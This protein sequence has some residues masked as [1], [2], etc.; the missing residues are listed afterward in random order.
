MPKVDH[1]GVHWAPGAIAFLHQ[2]D[3]A[4]NIIGLGEPSPFSVMSRGA[5]NH[6]ILLET[7]TPREHLPLFRQVLAQSSTARFLLPIPAPQPG[8]VSL[9]P[10][11]TPHES[12][13]LL[14]Q[15]L[16]M[17]S[18]LSP[19]LYAGWNVPRLLTALDR[20][21]V[22]PVVLTE[23]RTTDAANVLR[24]CRRALLAPSKL[25]VQVD[26]DFPPSSAFPMLTLAPHNLI[27]LSLLPWEAFGAT[28]LRAHMRRNWDEKTDWFID[29]GD[30]LDA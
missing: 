24:L 1:Y 30:S 28:V 17:S 3:G 5:C 9:Y 15:L 29:E 23:G 2:D 4:R 22:Q 20:T 6:H 25:L 7:P 8:G 26:M 19:P 18:P 27:D 12:L 16:R 11:E 21:N 13:R 14:A 10:T